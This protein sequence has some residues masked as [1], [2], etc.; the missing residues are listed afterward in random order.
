MSHVHPAEQ[1]GIALQ[2]LYSG[3]LETRDEH[4]MPL[5]EPFLVLGNVPARE[6]LVGKHSGEKVLS[7]G[8]NQSEARHFGGCGDHNIVVRVN[9]ADSETGKAEILG[10]AVDEMHSFPNSGILQVSCFENFHDAYE[11]RRAE[12]RPRIN[13]VAYEMDSFGFNEADEQVQFVSSH[14]RAQWIRWISHQD[15]F[16]P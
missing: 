7:L 3:L 1:T 11:F 16:D 15:A 13:L 6:F 10:K 8:R 14:R 12:N 4:F 5:P 2:A 9:R